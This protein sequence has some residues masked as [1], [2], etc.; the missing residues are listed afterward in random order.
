MTAPTGRPAPNMAQFLARLNA[1]APAATPDIMSA[2]VSDV[3]TAETDI[4]LFTDM[5][6]FDFDM[7]NQVDMS[8]HLGF[9]A[10][11]QQAAHGSAVKGLDFL[12]GA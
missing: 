2:A 3:S 9:G 4:G 1:N 5:Q 12:E 11:E 10:V 7:G 8:Q 6:F